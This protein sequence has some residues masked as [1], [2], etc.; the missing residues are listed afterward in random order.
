[1][2][3][4]LQS[5]LFISVDLQGADAAAPDEI[6]PTTHLR[7]NLCNPTRSVPEEQTAFARDKPHHVRQYDA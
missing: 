3:L 4:L 6:E 7:F 2:S 5:Q 1:M